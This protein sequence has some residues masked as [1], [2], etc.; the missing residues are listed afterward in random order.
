MDAFEDDLGHRSSFIRHFA[1]LGSALRFPMAYSQF[2]GKPNGSHEHIEFDDSGFRNRNKSN[3]HDNGGRPRVFVLGGSTMVEGLDEADTVPGRLETLLRRGGYPDAQVYNF[4]VVSTCFAQMS[5]LVWSH[6]APLRPDACVVVGGGTDVTNPW[7]FDPRPGQP[8]NGFVLE[9]IYDYLFDTDRLSSR[10]LGLSY[11]A[12]T[13]L[14]Y[15]R[16][17]RLRQQCG[18]RTEAWETAIIDRTA[19]TLRSFSLLAASLRIPV[20]CV[21][22]PTVVRTRSTALQD[23]ASQDFLAY[24]DRQY[25]R[26]QD[27]V[28]T[29]QHSERGNR[30]YRVLDFSGIFADRHPTVFYDTAHYT[31]EGRQ[32]MAERLADEITKVVRPPNAR[33]AASLRPLRRIRDLVRAR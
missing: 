31:A 20:L 7:T 21:L 3:Y 23:V 29:L 25:G 32:I 12:L 9:Q 18:W 30:A 1:H 19:E 17:E 5:A 24:L 4:G 14:L 13:D 8:F 6:L 16:L 2:S 28:R 10:E 27:L 15:R 33:G 22:Q 11:D 26:L